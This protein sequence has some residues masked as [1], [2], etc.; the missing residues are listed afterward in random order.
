[1]AVT[2]A[3]D[4]GAPLAPPEVQPPEHRLQRIVRPS[5]PPTL[6]D[7]LNEVLRLKGQT[8]EQAARAMGVTTAEVLAWTADTEPPG[9]AGMAS[10][11]AYLDVDE[12][13][14]RGLVLRGQMRL[15]Q[16][17]IRD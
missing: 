17:R 3:S 12:R 1:M 14:L 4:P 8:S 9:T 15:I 11:R 16:A 10:L 6:G 13:Q 5:R 2:N 7:K